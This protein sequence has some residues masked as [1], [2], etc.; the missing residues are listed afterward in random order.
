MMLFLDV[1]LD[2]KAAS[3]NCYYSHGG[4]AIKN[5]R[6]EEVSVKSCGSSHKFGLL[7]STVS[8]SW[9]LCHGNRSVVKK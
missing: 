1:N 7:N 9:E 2:G 6:K 3:Y 8:T 5:M 4:C